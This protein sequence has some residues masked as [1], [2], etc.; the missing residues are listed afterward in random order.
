ML[1]PSLEAYAWIDEEKNLFL[2]LA[3]DETVDCGEKTVLRR[4]K[5]T[6]DA[7][8]FRAFKKLLPII[9]Q[10]KDLEVRYAYY[11]VD[12]R[13]AA[14]AAT[15]ATSQLAETKAVTENRT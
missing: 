15:T 4:Q 13:Y 2:T 7:R 8:E 11:K 10:I 14:E 12:K 6:L 9:D 3:R 1:S 5:L